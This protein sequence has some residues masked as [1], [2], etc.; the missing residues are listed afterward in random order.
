M[1]QEHGLELNHIGRL[2]AIEFKFLRSIKGN[3]KK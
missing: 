3:N 1:V 2:K